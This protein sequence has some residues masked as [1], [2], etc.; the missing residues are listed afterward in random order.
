MDDF[1]MMLLR[2][3]RKICLKTS[4]HDYRSIPPAYLAAIAKVIV[5]PVLVSGRTR[6]IG[7]AAPGLRRGPNRA[8][9]GRA[10][11]NLAG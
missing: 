9:R 7:S 11:G 4:S 10:G 1:V 8:A 5:I 2:E 6:Q 3:C